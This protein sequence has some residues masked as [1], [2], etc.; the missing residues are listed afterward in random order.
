MRI[1]QKQISTL[2]ELFNAFIKVNDMTDNELIDEIEYYFENCN[3]E[4][5]NLRI[6]EIIL[7]ELRRRGYEL[8]VKVVKKGEQ[9]GK[10]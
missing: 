5:F 10:V 7:N 6:L 1:T 2:W 4:Y 9:H 3:K 8:K